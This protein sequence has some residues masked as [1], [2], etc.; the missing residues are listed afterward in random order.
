MS[1]LLCLWLPQTWIFLKLI[2]IWDHVQ[3]WRKEVLH[4]PKSM[5]V[6]PLYARPDDGLCLFSHAVLILFGYSQRLCFLTSYI[7]RLAT[8][9]R[10]VL[11]PICLMQN[12]RKIYPCLS[13]Q[14]AKMSRVT[15]QHKDPQK[16]KRK[17]LG[18]IPCKCRPLWEAV[19]RNTSVIRCR[20]LCVWGN[21]MQCCS[22]LKHVM[23]HLAW[24]PVDRKTQWH[25][26]WVSRLLLA[27]IKPPSKGIELKLGK[28]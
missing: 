13:H 4:H 12:C 10:C 19:C 7:L 16:Y 22:Q 1:L 20:V 28:L 18:I 14:Y 21:T 27:F 2:V 5:A 8:C 6:V 25:S 11:V 26:R 17:V 24:M 23:V 15:C 3:L 9:D